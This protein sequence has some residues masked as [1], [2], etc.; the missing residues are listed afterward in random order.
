[1]ERPENQCLQVTSRCVC[2]GSGWSVWMETLTSWGEETKPGRWFCYLATRLLGGVPKHVCFQLCA[3]FF[4]L[5]VPL[6]SD[7]FCSCSL[8]Q[9]SIC[10][11]DKKSDSLREMH[12]VGVEST[13]G[14]TRR[15]GNIK[16]LLQE[17][18]CFCYLGLERK[19]LE[20]ISFGSK[21]FWNKQDFREHIHYIYK[22]WNGISW[23]ITRLN[24][25]Q[26]N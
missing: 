23:K 15:L 25:K 19:G 20:H 21:M 22:Q 5:S 26:E 6:S 1:M 18:L 24:F 12:W 8:C 2:T 14:M 4:A 7:R 13:V 3:D 17:F 11:L 9:D 10:K 16:S